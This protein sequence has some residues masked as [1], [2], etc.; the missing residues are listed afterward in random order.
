MPSSPSLYKPLG[1]EEDEDGVQDGPSAQEKAGFCS[2]LLFMWISPLLSKGYR[3]KLEMEDLPHNASEMRSAAMIARWRRLWADSARHTKPARRVVA[4][5]WP[6]VRWTWLMQIGMKIIG[7]LLRFMQPIC[8]QE[9]IRWLGDPEIEPPFWSA[10]VPAESRGLFYVAVMIG[11]MLLQGV[12]Y[13]HCFFLGGQ[14]A[15]QARSATLLAIYEKALAQA[16]HARADTTTGK[17]VNLMSSDC[18]RLQW[19]MPWTHLILTG[20]LQF[21]IAVVML[22]KLIGR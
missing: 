1:Q 7:D 4:V 10:P 18:T 2:K 16:V 12:V 21:G 19:Y 11:A 20:T 5:M 14:M 6:F 15:F 13:T 3:K 22:W 17:V 8:L 9:I